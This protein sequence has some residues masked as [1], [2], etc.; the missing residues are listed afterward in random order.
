MTVTVMH[1]APA[2]HTTRSLTGARRVVCGV[3]LALAM[4]TPSFAIEKLEGLPPWRVGGRM[5]FTTDI[6]LYPDTVGYQAEVYLRIPPATIAQL[7]RDEQGRAQLRATVKLKPRT[8]EE[9]GSTQEFSLLPGDTLN[10]EGHVVVLHFPGTPGPCRVT[11]RL[12]DLL[13]RKRGI[14]YSGRNS[15][16]NTELQGQVDLPRPQAGRDLSDLEFLWPSAGHS[17][18][19]GFVRAGRARLPNPDRLYGLYSGLL[20]ASFTARSKPGDERPWHWIA[21]VF[22][23]QGKVVA[24]QESTA[25]EGRFMTADVRFDL[26]DQPAGSY[27]LDTKVWQEGDAGSLQR[28]ARFSI[29]WEADTWNRNAAD[30]ADEVHFLLESREEETFAV[31]QP[32]EQEKMLAEFWKKR[33]P[34]PETAVNEALLTYRDRVEYAN[35]QWSRFGLG[36][37]MFTDMGRVY[38]RY[39]APTEV[40]HQVM[41]AG[42]ETLSK[43]LEDI[44]ASE[45][46]AVG[47]INQKGPGGDQRPYEVWTYQG[48]IPLPFDVEPGSV[49]AGAG[50][51]R[52]LFLFVDE[53]GLGTFTLRYSTE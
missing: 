22:D 34:T 7:E 4:A 36:K 6:A 1:G 8:G 49:A 42:Q 40:A 18:G 9:L 38:I 44:M 35:T 23:A 51:K 46:R 30:I 15:L 33:D 48:D 17:L 29:G 5:G 21:R 43:V 10:G 20:E 52:L 26:A 41:P 3:L 13:G 19:L 28:R 32:G 31:L 2:S 47:E 50:K 45:T 16:Q 11:A 27:Q 12:E 14:V 53:Q 37:G 39:G 24:Q 25:V